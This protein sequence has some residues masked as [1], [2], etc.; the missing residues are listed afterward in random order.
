MVSKSVFHDLLDP[1]LKL[2]LSFRGM[3]LRTLPLQLAQ[4]K[5]GSTLRLFVFLSFLVLLFLAVFVGAELSVFESADEKS[6][7]IER[8]F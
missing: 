7:A 2:D 4:P 6:E 5:I 8:F 1:P 3:L